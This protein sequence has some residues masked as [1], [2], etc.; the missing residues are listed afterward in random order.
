MAGTPFWRETLFNAIVAARLMERVAD[1]ARERAVGLN[2]RE[3]IKR[4]KNKFGAKKL[5]QALLVFY[6]ILLYGVVWCAAASHYWH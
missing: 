6:C 4:Q 2:P 3:D 5:L 1:F